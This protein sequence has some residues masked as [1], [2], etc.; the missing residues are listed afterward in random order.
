[1]KCWIIIRFSRWRKENIYWPFQDFCNN[2]EARK[3]PGAFYTAN[4]PVGYC[5]EN[6]GHSPCQLNPLS[7]D[8]CPSHAY[9]KIRVDFPIVY[10]EIFHLV[11]LNREKRKISIKI[12]GLVVKPIEGYRSHKFRFISTYT[13]NDCRLCHVF[14]ELGQTLIILKMSKRVLTQKSL[15]RYI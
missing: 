3:Y 8:Y 14:L 6:Q 1:M 10:W 5:I 15:W 9:L 11:S 2:W 7:A 12:S 13:G 4:R